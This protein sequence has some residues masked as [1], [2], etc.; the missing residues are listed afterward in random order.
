[1]NKT[2]GKDISRSITKDWKRFL[3]IV[4]ITALGVAMLTGLYASCKDMYYSADRFYDKQNLFDIRILSTLG[5]TQEDVEALSKLNGIDLVE[6]AYSEAVHT[7][8]EGG[9]KSVTLSVL[10]N[11]GLN[12]PYVLEGALPSNVK[13]IAVTEKYLIES[14]K[15]IGDTVTIAEDM[16]TDTS[17]EDKDKEDKEEPNFVNTTY[18]ITGKVLDPMDIQSDGMASVIRSSEQSDYTFFVTEAAASFDIYT[19]VYLTLTNTQELNSYSGEYE[20]AVQQVIDYIEMHIK[21]EREAAR[22]SAVLAEA[23]TKL[24]DAKKEMDEEFQKA[25]QEFADAWEEITEGKQKLLDGENTLNQEEKDAAK[26][27]AD[28]RAE[29]EEAKKKLLASEKQLKEGE[30]KLNEGEAELK[31][32]E[33]ELEAG[34]QQFEA[35]KTQ[36][37]EQLNIAQKQLDQTQEQLDTEGAELED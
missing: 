18:T 29:L 19:A 28:A 33:K 30:A 32:R 11:R 22:Y 10:S 8:V 15:S 36:A 7:Q 20:E 1:M 23:R 25:D 14:G 21:K 34:R 24:D 17:T 6:G 37:M 26:Q 13:E 5:L 3:S 9:R 35:E 12:N 31:A 16:D 2:Y 27:F 4:I